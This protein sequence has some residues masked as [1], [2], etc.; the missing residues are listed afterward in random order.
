M[1]KLEN[2]EV[3]EKIELLIYEGKKI[4]AIKVVREITSMGLKESKEHID[5]LIIELYEKNPDKFKH[6]P[7]KAKGCGTAALF[8]LFSFI[9]IYFLFL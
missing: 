8:F 5:N 9:G 1:D 2:R 6:D 7:T 3:S 4:D